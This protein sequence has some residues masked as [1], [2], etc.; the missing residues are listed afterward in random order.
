MGVPVLI[1]GESGSGK[2]TSLRNFDAD[3]VGVFNVASKPLP[4]RKKMLTVDIN[5]KTDRYQQIQGVLTRNKLKCYVI[6]DANYLMTFYLFDKAKEVGYQKFTDC[7]LK[8]E[9]LVEHVIYNTS[10]DTIVYFLQHVE[11]TE[12]GKI[13]AKT[14]GKMLD[15]QLTLEGLFTIVLMA[16]TDGKEHWFTTQ[17]DGFTT[18][19]SP[20][21]MFDSVKIPNDLAMVDEIIRKYY[22][23]DEIKEEKQKGE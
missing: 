13:K 5:G 21:E 12:R 18:C 19:K 14:A 9:R 20:L 6:D 8:F 7:A 11:E 17:S 3:K 10:P 16:E 4:F 23:F 15:N 22:Y 1:M 2:S